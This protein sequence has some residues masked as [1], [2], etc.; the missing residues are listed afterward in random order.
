VRSESDFNGYHFVFLSICGRFKNKYDTKKISHFMH[1]P[2]AL[3]YHGW[4]G[5]W[6]VPASISL[7]SVSHSLACDPALAWWKHCGSSVWL[8]IFL[9]CKAMW[10][11]EVK[12]HPPWHPQDLWGYMV[13]ESQ[14]VAAQSGTEKRGGSQ[15]GCLLSLS[16]GVGP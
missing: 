9:A 11:V 16:L 7:L 1:F 3:W 5:V 6:S 15:P 13:S 8:H 2:A 10:V 4:L 14:E 12:T